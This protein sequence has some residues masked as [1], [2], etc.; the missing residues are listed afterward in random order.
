[1]KSSFITSC[2]AALLLACP[3]AMAQDECASAPVL[4]SGVASAFNTATATATATPAVDDTLCAGTFLNWLPTQQDVW[5]QYTATAAGTITVTTCDAASYDTSIV[6][7]SGSC[8]A[9]TPV[10][11][12]GDAAADAACQGFYSKV[13]DL[14]V[15]AGTTYFVRVGGYD[16][17][18]G[19]GNLLLT[20][21]Q[22]VDGCAGATGDCAQVHASVGCNVNTCCSAVCAVV[23]DCCT[24]TWD[25][26]CVDEANDFCAQCGDTDAT[27]FAPH[28]GHGCSDTD[29]CALVTAVDSTCGHFE[30]DAACAELAM[31]LCAGCGLPTAGDCRAVH[32]TPGCAIEECCT[33][34]CAADVYCCETEWDELCVNRANATCG[35]TGDL[36]GDGQRDASDLAF[37]LGAWGTAGGDVNGDG[38]T[39]AS[40]LAVL[41]GGWGACP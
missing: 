30:W 22:G 1:M 6:I 36:N 4:T 7:Y 24:V 20:F 12:N 8:G 33:S 3:A 15:S 18:V 19:A 10:A 26:T 27:C 23:P 9:L 38:T 35:L 31:T 16:G 37:M 29:C 40:D 2:A 17:A 32:A 34:V 41:L 21:T 25:Q 11:C 13:S 28:A 14:P 39:D 5:F